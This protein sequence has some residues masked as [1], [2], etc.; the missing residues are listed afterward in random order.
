MQEKIFIMGEA[1][2]YPKELEKLGKD[3]PKEIHCVGNIDLLNR[4]I[5]AIVGTR[6]CTRYGKEVAKELAAKLAENGVIVI[7]GLAEGI[8]TKAHEGAGAENTI[9]VLGNGL[10]YYSPESNR[11]L[12]KE[13]AEK[14]L[15]LT[16]YSFDT[17]AMSYTFVQRN[18][19]IAALAKVI[20]IV[21]ADE[22][23]GALITARHAI[24]LN[25]T[26]YAV[27]GNITSDTS[28]GT[29]ALIKNGEAKIMTSYDDILNEFHI[30]DS[31]FI[32][33]QIAPIT[34]EEKEILDIIGG[35]E[36]HFDEIKEKSGLAVHVLA[37]RL[38]NMEMGGLLKKLAGNLYAK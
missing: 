34:D 23:S 18:R 20:V 35:D 4:P 27:C 11:A 15:L 30:K 12:Q 3:A 16:E 26:L 2:E 37:S 7:S 31:V 14:G 32:Q 6:K 28:K 36:V 10:G 21:E 5:C 33:Q 13:I 17:H 25:K 24:E 38:T 8:D 19:I 1:K 9:A 22:K 29:N